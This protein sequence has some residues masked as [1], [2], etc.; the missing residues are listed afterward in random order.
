MATYSASQL[1]IK[2]PEGGFKDLGW[3][4]GSNG[5]S[6]QYVGGT[7]GE[8]KTI[9]PNSPQQ[10]AGKEVSNEVVAQTDP[11]NVSYLASYKVPATPQQ[12]GNDLNSF[13]TEAYNSAN[14]IN[15]KSIDQL[16]SELAPSTSLPPLLNRVEE[17]TKLTDK[18]KVAD[19]ESS[20]NELKAQED[21]AVAALRQRTA[22]ERGQQVAQGVI[23]GRI[24][25]ETR[26]AQEQIDFIQRQKSRVV[27]ELNTR[28]NIINTYI[29]L[30]GLDYN[31]AVARYDKEFE[32]NL[33][34]YGII[35]NQIDRNL[36]QYNKDRAFAQAN[37][38]TYVNLITKGNLDINNLS[39]DDKVM[40]SK[41]EVQAGFS[42]GF[43]ASVKK[44]PS[45][46]ILFTTSNEGVTQVG[47][48][49]SDGTIS[50]QS[51]GTRISSSKQSQAEIEKEAVGD[52]ASLLE[53]RKVSNGKVPPKDWSELRS[54]WLQEGFSG[55]VFDKAFR[56]QYVDESQP[57]S[58]GF[59]YH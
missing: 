40:L 8:N 9:H 51:Y 59:N 20:L 10:G 29:N 14:Q 31:D 35:E 13:Q 37:L 1:G 6:F 15:V 27:D 32:Q 39:G 56:S 17:Y 23:E 16:K 50:V 33:Q 34:I 48:R 22:N 24:S 58:Y 47:F 53:S 11:K 19:L 45:A 28:Y 26:Q 44:D 25:E 46:D 49:N 57:E 18:Y 21:E 36:D 41:L 7:F 3:Y 42:P 43:I 54:Y 12:L 55:E 30:M 38:Q 5:G 4:P 2:A 52:M